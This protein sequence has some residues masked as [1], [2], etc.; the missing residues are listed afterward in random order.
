M[1]TLSDAL[2]SRT[3]PEATAAL[4]AA[5]WTGLERTRGQYGP[6]KIELQGD[7]KQLSDDSLTARL[8]PGS[9]SELGP[10][11][12][13]EVAWG[14]GGAPAVVYLVSA[15]MYERLAGAPPFPNAPAEA[16]Q[17]RKLLEPVPTLPPGVPAALAGLVLKGAARGGPVQPGGAAWRASGALSL[18]DLSAEPCRARA[19]GADRAPPPPGEP[20]AK[21][22]LC[23]R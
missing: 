11:L 23:G 19:D 10:H 17:V 9:A 3:G 18:T 21:G 14:R 4:L 22:G 13:P 8:K 12:A 6:E 16:L 5:C 1:Q 15:L 7:L 2:R 20:C